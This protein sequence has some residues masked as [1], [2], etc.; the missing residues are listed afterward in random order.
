M[1]PYLELL[2]AICLFLLSCRYS[3]WPSIFDKTEIKQWEIGKGLLRNLDKFS[4]TVL[5]CFLHWK[6]KIGDFLS[7]YLS[8][9]ALV[10]VTHICYWF[11]E[12][13]IRQENLKMDLNYDV[14]G[15]I[16]YILV[17]GGIWTLS[18]LLYVIV[19]NRYECFNLDVSVIAKY[20]LIPW[21]ALV[22]GLY[23]SSKLR[24]SKTMSI[25]L[26][27]AMIVDIFFFLHEY[28]A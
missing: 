19:N 8:G 25:L 11:A 13:K 26:W 1:S 28:W 5:Y 4:M 27:V 14:P 10:L 9:Y 6:L 24:R 21:Y 3:I 7:F 12:R 23:P 18:V 2:V 22:H 16:K 17:A 15:Y 20:S